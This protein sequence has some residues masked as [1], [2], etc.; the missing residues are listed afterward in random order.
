[1]FWYHCAKCMEVFW[2]SHSF[3]HEVEWNSP[4]FYLV[5]LTLHFY[6]A[7]H[8]LQN[9]PAEIFWPHF[10]FFYCF[11]KSTNAKILFSLLCI[12]HPCAATMLIFSFLK[13]IAFQNWRM[14]KFSS[15]FIFH[16]CAATMLISSL[17]LLL[18]KIG[19]INTMLWCSI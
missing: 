10:S 16:P 8:K 14:K 6:L 7:A 5:N 1:M 2:W 12:C 15:V 11:S 4:Y 13:K 19:E 9:A 3:W 17:F 18:F